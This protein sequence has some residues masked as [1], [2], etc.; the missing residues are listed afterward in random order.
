MPDD[1]LTI[2]PEDGLQVVRF[3]ENAILDTNTIQ[4]I[5]RRLYELVSGPTPAAMLLD[6]AHVRFLAS[7]ALG[8]LLTL[9]RKA[10]EAGATLAL[11]HLRPE[12]HRV[13][14]VTKIDQVLPLFEEE[15]EAREFLR[16]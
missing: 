13:F 14:V 6:F 4:G 9:Q 12:L 7:Q 1:A 3:R 16:K 2:T 10:K 8:M 11:C 15:G 5:S